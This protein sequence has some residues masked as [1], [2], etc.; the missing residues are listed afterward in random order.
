MSSCNVCILESKTDLLIIP[1]MV[2]F[3]LH[4]LTLLYFIRGSNLFHHL[5][6]LVPS[7][8]IASHNI[9][10]STTNIERSIVN[11]PSRQRTLFKLY[12]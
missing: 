6:T 9:T 2:D 5:F 8:C 4:L 7:H 1:E 10:I 12:A 3:R 11:R